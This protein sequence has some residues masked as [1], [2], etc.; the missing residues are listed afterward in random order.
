MFWQ[1]DEDKSLP[2]QIPEDIIDLSFAISCKTLPLD[3]AW[4]LS[5]AILE[6]LPWLT[7]EVAGIHHIH[8]AESNN[9][10]MR[11]TDDEK[12]ALLYPSH[13]T[14]MTLRIPSLKIE[15][16][17]Q[18]LTG[19]TLLIDGH[20]LTVGK[21]KK[22]ELTN[23]SV[24]FSR[25]VLSSTKENENDFLARIAQEV[26]QISGFKVKKMLC[27]KTHTIN[28]PSERLLTRHLMIADLDSE[29]SVKIQQQGL[30]D[31]RVLGCGIFL[32]HKGI[33][34]LNSSE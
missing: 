4:V 26:K 29:S 18:E 8:V 11:P 5:Q 32:P 3:H 15:Q 12:G 16:A 20:K 25:H 22:K 13:R 23:D 27:G 30:G 31:A 28:T 14:K 19:K 10:W 17:N 1:E 21:S 34:S 7:D 24:I 33:K 9:G 6:H 2:Y